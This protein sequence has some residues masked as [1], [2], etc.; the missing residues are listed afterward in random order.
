MT[1][2]PILGPVLMVIF[3]R[4]KIGAWTKISLTNLKTGDLM[5][6]RSNQRRFQWWI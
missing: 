4:L 1:F 2:G 6:H 3:K 5:L